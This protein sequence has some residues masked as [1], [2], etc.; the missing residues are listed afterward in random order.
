M[1]HV[2]RI[3]SYLFLSITA[4]IAL[5]FAFIELRSLLAGDFLLMNNQATSFIGYLCRGL[6]FIFLMG[7]AVSVLIFYLLKIEL[8]SIHYVIAV[9][10][11]L[12]SLFSVAFYTSYIYL[13]IVS[14]SVIPLIIVILRKSVK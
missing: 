2:G 4:L 13:L 5:V 10:L 9:S 1:R 7:F 8:S 14:I 12:A 3:V 6:F 11:A